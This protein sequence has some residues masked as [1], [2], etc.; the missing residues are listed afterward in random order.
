MRILARVCATA[1]VVIA[2]AV[3]SFAQE[4]EGPDYDAWDIVAQRAEAAVEAGRASDQALDSLRKEIVGWRESFQEQLT[5]NQS[6][7]NTINEQIE[8]LGPVPEEGE[9]EALEISERRAALSEQERRL[10]TPR[11]TAEE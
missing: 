9:V 7:L 8:S 6:R 11:L 2:I 3:S 4:S 10:S 1:F 5:A